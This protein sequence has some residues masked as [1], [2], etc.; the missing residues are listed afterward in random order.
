MFFCFLICLV[1]CLLCFLDCGKLDLECARALV[2]LALVYSLAKGV[3]RYTVWRVDVENKS[4]KKKGT[5]NYICGCLFACE[6]FKVK[7]LD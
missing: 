6:D 3:Y 1:F 4:K 5:A 2:R 7:R